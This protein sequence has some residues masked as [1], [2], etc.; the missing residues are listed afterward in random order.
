MV[1]A[2]RVF[3]ILVLLASR[4]SGASAAPLATLDA[5]LDGNAAHLELDATGHLTIQTKNGATTIAIAPSI[6]RAKLA[7]AQ[8]KG[9]TVIVIEATTPNGDEAIVL[10]GPS[11]TPVI[12]T[13]L[14]VVGLDRDYA[15]AIDVRPEGIYR[16]Q[17]REGF[18][19]C[20]GKPG[21]LF[22]EGWDGAKF[23]K[24]A[25]VPTDVPDAA[26]IVT[27]RIDRAP[28]EPPL[29]YQAKIASHEPGAQDSGR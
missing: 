1:V 21:Y 6:T 8:L 2:V 13:P 23:R 12:T 10:G 25:R 9:A 3:L 16:Y 4:V 29:I 27:A 7:T 26:P 28:A 22:A 19:R 17:T 24:L 11:W 5:D 15:T 18:H 14:D 20:D